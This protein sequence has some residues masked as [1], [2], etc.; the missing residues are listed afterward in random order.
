[1]GCNCKKQP[2]I[3]YVEPTPIITPDPFDN[4]DEFFTAPIPEKPIQSN[5]ENKT[6]NNG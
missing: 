3:Q 1:M 2:T 6:D 4:T 5:E